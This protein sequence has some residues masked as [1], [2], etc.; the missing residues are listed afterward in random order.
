MIVVSVGPF[1][2]FP[3]LTYRYICDI[4]DTI[5]VVFVL[6]CVF[7][8]FTIAYSINNIYLDQSQIAF[9]G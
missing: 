4:Q 5:D 2:N 7:P 3:F 8:I 1:S 6:V 9:Y